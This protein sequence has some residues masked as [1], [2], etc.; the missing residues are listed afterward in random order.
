MKDV[1]DHL[2]VSKAVD[3]FLLH[4]KLLKKFLLV[5]VSSL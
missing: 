5:S 2:S 4:T 1:L 3:G